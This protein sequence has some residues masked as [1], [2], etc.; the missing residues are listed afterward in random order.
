MHNASYAPKQQLRLKPK[1][2]M[3]RSTVVCAALPRHALI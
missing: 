1:N 2:A 3:P